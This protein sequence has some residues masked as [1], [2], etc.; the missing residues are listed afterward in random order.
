M[1]TNSVA[2][3]TPVASGDPGLLGRKAL[4]LLHLA[5]LV[6]DSPF[7]VPKFRI[8]SGMSFQ[9]RACSSSSRPRATDTACRI[10]G[11]Q[12]V[13][14][15]ASLAIMLKD[16]DVVDRIG[17]AVREFGGRTQVWLRSSIAFPGS[18]WSLAGMNRTRSLDPGLDERRAIGEL[19]DDFATLSGRAYNLWYAAGRH[20]GSPTGLSVI[21]SCGFASLLDASITF[22]GDDACI[23]FG[24]PGNAASWSCA[25]VRLDAVAPRQSPLAGSVR[26]ERKVYDV[27]MW[28]RATC[29]VSEPIEVEL[30]FGASGETCI[31]QLRQLTT[32]NGM[33]A[34]RV[35]S[36]HSPGTFAAPVVDLR[37]FPRRVADVKRLADELP[38]HPLLLVHGASSRYLDAFAILWAS[39]MWDGFPPVRLGVVTRESY[40]RNHLVTAAIEDDCI[41][42][43]SQ[44]SGVTGVA[45]PKAVRI[46]SDG[47]GCRVSAVDSR[48][49][50]HGKEG[51][52]E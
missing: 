49:L 34:R 38:S 37:D 7:V 21:V 16:T 5:S 30:G 33:D 26:L 25:R 44:F 24:E 8:V 1:T 20:L 10:P 11:R 23:D 29:G 35:G 48:T 14:A 45:W 47:I 15:D 17:A 28:L 39:R 52:D 3:S 6:E 27:A 13:E 42:S 32:K 9:R 19:L 43:V 12:S 51:A 46:R 36:H 50:S 18:L 22:L 40:V 2:D 31:Y 4:D 41:L